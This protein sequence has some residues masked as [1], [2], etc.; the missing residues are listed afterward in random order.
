MSAQ[1]E[2]AVT[3]EDR[4]AQLTRDLAE[5]NEQQTATSEVL[6]VIGRSD[7]RLEPVFETVVRQAVRLCHCRLR[8]RLPARR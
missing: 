8:L 4:I 7:F 2:P 1:S 5:A 6:A 3:S